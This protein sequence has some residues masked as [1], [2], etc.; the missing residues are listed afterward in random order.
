MDELGSRNSSL[1]RKKPPWLK[2]DIPTI[3]LT[4]DDSATHT[5]PVKRLRSVSM[6]GENPQTCIAALETSN[7]YLRPPLERQPSITQSIKSD[8]RVRFER[9]NTVPPKGQR[10]PRRVSAVRRRSC[11]PK[12][13]SRRRSSIP[14]QIIRGT[15]DWFGVSKDSDS[16]QRW[17]RKSLQHCR[18][19]YGGLK[20]Q[21]MREMELHSQDNLSLASTETPPPIY[22]PPLHP[23]HHHYGMQRIVD[24]LAR[25]R[26]FRM[27]EEVGGFSVPQT[28]LT[29]GT[30]SLCSFSS[31]RSALNRLPRRRKRESV[32]VMSLKAAAALM[33]GR[34]LGESTAG[35]HRRRSFMPPSFFED[36]TVD[37]SDDLDTSF[38]TRDGLQDELS[39]YA[40][41]VFET[42]SEAALDQLDESEL[43]GS[44]L[45]KNELERSHLMLPLERGWRKTKDGPLVQP[46]VRLKQ[47]VV[48][49]GSHQQRGHRIV[50]PVKKLF[51]REKRPY[52]LGMVGR[53]TNRTY[54]KRIDSFVKRQIEDMDDHRPFFTYW[55]TFVHLLITILAVTI[56]GIAP[57]GFSQHETVD[58]VLR[59]KG[60]YE[61]VKFVQQ[62][63]F[64]VGPSSEALIHLG[65]KFSPCMR[66]DQEIQKLIQEKRARESESGCCVRND[67]SGCLQ[68]LQE[69]CSSTLAVW[70]KWP[71]HPS[72][73]HL[74]GDVRQHGSVCHQDPRIC[75][76]PAS[77]SPHEW[78]DDITKWP[79]CTRFNSG[80][81]TNL[82]HIDC[83]ITGRP[84]CIG[85]KGRCEITSR[86]YCDF[87]HG[88]FHE[89]A[90]LCSQVACMDDVCGLLPFLNPDI[91]DQFSRLWLSL[92]LHA[93]I[94]HCLVSVLFQMTVLRDI[95]KLAGW[96]R[97]SIVYLLSGVT[98][99][100]ASAIF[101]PYRAEVGP[102]GSQFGIL[103]CLFVELFQS[104][105]ILERP[106]WAFAKL[107]AISV[108][109]F[110]FGLLPW[111]DNFAHIC[112][113]I[114]G[115]FLSFAFLP[116]ISFGRSD[117][118]RKRVQICV[119]LLVF[120]AL[121]SA[122]AVLFYVYPV[123]CDWCEYLTCI[124]I[125]DKFCEKYD[126]NAHLH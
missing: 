17:R 124:P 11:V 52:G 105:Q 72:A 104:W 95:E 46:Q 102:A 3:Q 27:V 62:E 92:F 49:V 91:P 50:V 16:T 71:Q 96:L 94:L 115:F 8:K 55:I 40:D 116:Y 19:L 31:S 106:W 54:R 34:T 63:N 26:A 47:E 114:S 12:I 42:P 4:P 99:N 20:A 51:A 5:Q 9:V 60:V 119:F 10:S 83:T 75:L 45:D 6:P 21:V 118:F 59:N 84:C 58:S 93:G 109:F 81:H 30:A 56:Y 89:E 80:N 113:F 70:V 98:G 18:H 78:P 117:M 100:L 88:Y 2:L 57:V 1:Q 29:P 110:S 66:R 69:E 112:G 23:S 126:L 108:F 101:L 32:A 67:R 107:L 33:K 36:D 13:L 97:I 37:F 76:E 121:L 74:N 15:A 125:T 39:S 48:S 64:W 86:E 87:M 7:N 123:K 35:R 61:N 24:P 77:V 73:P 103:A 14:K 41:E 22:L 85:T 82:P 79:V 111:I 53:L 25:G 44:A 28:P 38:F 120:M 43:T 68:T 65:A 90:T 122:L